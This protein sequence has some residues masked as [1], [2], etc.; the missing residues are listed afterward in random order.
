M[1][2]F[3]SRTSVGDAYYSSCR[4]DASSENV[5]SFPL[6]ENSSPIRFFFEALPPNAR[7]ASLLL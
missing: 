3:I 1:P 7:L 6:L 2:V 5:L 4:L